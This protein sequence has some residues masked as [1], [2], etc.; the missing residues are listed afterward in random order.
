MKI[1][2]FNASRISP[3]L[4]AL[5]L[6]CGAMPAWA[7][8]DAHRGEDVF[9]Q[10]CAECHSAKEGKNKKGPSLFAVV[11][12]KA[13]GIAD[14]VYSEAIKQSGITRSVSA[15]DAYLSA[16]RKAVPGG[17]MKFDGL[18]DAKDREDLLAYLATLR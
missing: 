17:K 15:L 12:R 11:G 14:F 7:G 5:A 8:G 2:N 13:A 1:S 4:C 6:G 3:W 16:P 18:A 9:A 10:E